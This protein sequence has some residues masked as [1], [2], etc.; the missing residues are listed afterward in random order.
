MHILLDHLEKKENVAEIFTDIE[1]TQSVE[2]E[3][4]CKK[5]IKF[6]KDSIITDIIINK[7]VKMSVSGNSKTS[8]FKIIMDK[9]MKK[10]NRQKNSC[11][12]S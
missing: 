5:I 10:L 9:K 7:M 4:F 6:Y 3:L 11:L 12:L 1:F 2:F 8:E